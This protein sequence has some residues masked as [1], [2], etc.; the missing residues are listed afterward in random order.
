MVKV[1]VDGVKRGNR[2]R[3]QA[4]LAHEECRD[5]QNVASSMV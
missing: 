2:V 5:C 4:K 3:A 1:V